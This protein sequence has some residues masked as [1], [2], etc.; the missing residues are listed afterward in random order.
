MK[1]RIVSA[2]LALA[3]PLC[4]QDNSADTENTFYKAFYLEKG[5]RDFAGAMDLYSK[6]LAAAP[7][8]KLAKTAA[9]QQFGLLNKTGKTKDRDAFREKYADLL[10]GAA[11]TGRAVADDAPARPGRGEGAEGRGRGEGGEGRGARGEGGADMAARIKDTEAELAKAKEAGDEEQVANLTRRLERMKEMAA[12]GGRGRG[13]GGEGR[14]GGRARG[15]MFGS[16][17]LA[18]MSADELKEFK[19]GLD[20][21]SGMIDRMRE[22]L[23]EDQAKALETNLSD[24]QK[25]LEGD[26]LDEAQKALDKM[27]ESFPNRRRGGGGGGR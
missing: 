21:M 19:A 23:D 26:K 20:R 18:E 9:R 7:D 6:F 12:G 24:L 17:K 25:A 14:Q 2:L 3:L 11:A 13:A 8:H 4:A 16:K 22:R 15:G 1:T 27:R 10:G 5:A